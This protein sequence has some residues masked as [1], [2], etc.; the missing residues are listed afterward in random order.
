MKISFLIPAFFLF[1]FIEATAQQSFVRNKNIIS[2]SVID[3]NTGTVV[4]DSLL[5]DV[6]ADGYVLLEFVGYCTASAG[7]RIVLAAS[8]APQVNYN[9]D[10]VMMKVANSDQ[11]RISFSHSRLYPV[12]TGTHDFYAMAE[13]Y[14]ETQGNGK[15]YVYATL[16]ATYFPNNVAGQP[17]VFQHNVDQSDVLAWNNTKVVGQVGFTA[18]ASGKVMVRLDGTCVSTPGDRIFLAATNGA[19]WDMQS[20]SVSVEAIS[21]ELLYNPFS[22]SRI[23]D[24]DPGFN[25][26]YGVVSNMVETD[27]SGTA[28]VYGSLTVV[29]YPETSPVQLLSDSIVAPEVQ[30]DGPVTVLAQK[31]INAPVAGKVIVR[32]DGTCESTPGDRIVLASSYWEGWIPNDGATAVEAYDEDVN[33]QTFSH[34]RVYDVAPGEHSYYAVGQNWVETDGN[35]IAGV[36]GNLTVQFF[37]AEALVPT[38]EAEATIAS[39]FT[40]APNPVTD[41]LYVQCTDEL[42]TDEVRLEVFDTSGKLILSTTKPAGEQVAEVPVNMLPA[43]LHVLRVVKKDKVSVR[44]FVKTRS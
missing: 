2:N 20:G 38:T 1:S 44:N 11:N 39:Q 37:P 14:L 4:V 7:D 6:P 40:I 27:G 21:N 19:S 28:S 10:C 43:G 33:G 5:L 16:C 35:G 34:I 3:L 22:H 31:T 42:A 36:Y 24:V 13:R 30:L 18:P 32:F 8:D 23:F 9:E 15:I 25:L 12:Q 17:Q 41:M 29:Y 26:F